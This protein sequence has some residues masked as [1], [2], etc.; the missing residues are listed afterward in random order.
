L[1][2]FIRYRN[3]PAN[4]DSLGQNDVATLFQDREGNIWAGLHMM[5]PNRFSTTPPLFEKFKHESG[6]PNSLSGTMVN[7]IYEDREG[8][9]WISSLRMVQ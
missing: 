1:G 8:I 6:T 5:A 7:G 2:Y 3:D 4:P 9:L